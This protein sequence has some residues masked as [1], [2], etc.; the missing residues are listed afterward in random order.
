MGFG[1]TSSSILLATGLS[2][3]GVSAS[4]N[5]AKVATGIAAAISHWR[6]GN[7]DRSLVRRLAVPG[8]FGAL[9]GT[10]ILSNVDGDSIRPVLALLLMIIGVR[11]L[12]RF[13]SHLPQAKTAAE[14]A[15]Q[16]SLKGVE[17]AGA[18]GGVT[19]GL[20]GAWGPVVT[21]FLLHRG[22]QARFA[23]GSVNTAEVAVAFVAAGSLFT[24]GNTGVE[25]GTI[26]AMLVGGVLA[27]PVAAYTVRFVPA[28][29]LGIL[30]AGLLL[31]TNLRELSNW[32]DVGDA[33]WLAYAAVLA[34]VAVAALRPRAARRRVKSVFVTSS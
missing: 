11:I 16:A 30:V 18:V 10:V 27:S 19:N 28:R 3:A 14:A 12:F 6:F 29:L 32:Q 26:A 17:V 1:P 23:I 21:P 8:V 24:S 9:I 33:R 5:V 20:I 25:A 31:I 2:P 13:S 34:F 22:L 4:V 7:I 15:E